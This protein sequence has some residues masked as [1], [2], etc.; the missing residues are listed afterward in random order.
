MGR[1]DHRLLAPQKRAAG[2]MG[3]TRGPA[4]TLALESPFFSPVKVVPRCRVSDYQCYQPGEPCD[5]QEDKFISVIHRK[6][7]QSTCSSYYSYDWQYESQSAF[8]VMSCPI[9]KITETLWHHS[10]S[11]TSCV[12]L[13]TIVLQFTA[14][15]RLYMSQ[16]FILE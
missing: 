10:A 6:K 2:I 1:R 4:R 15:R 9:G 16:K 5:I 14:N 13:R 8:A 7:H 12:K 11:L 3:T